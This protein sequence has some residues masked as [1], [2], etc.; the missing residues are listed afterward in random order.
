MAPVYSPIRRLGV[1]TLATCGTAA[2]SRSVSTVSLAHGRHATRHHGMVVGFSEVAPLSHGYS[3]FAR[4]SLSHGYSDFRA[5]TFASEVG[6]PPNRHKPPY[7]ET[8]RRLAALPVRSP[9]DRS[10]RSEGRPKGVIYVIMIVL[11]LFLAWR[12]QRAGE[13]LGG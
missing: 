9:K 11:A 8:F 5:L 7:N 3:T 6:R 13:N 1:K 4:T 12:A 2:A 10:L